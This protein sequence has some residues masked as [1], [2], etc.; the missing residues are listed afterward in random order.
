MSIE[1]YPV[2]PFPPNWTSTVGETLEWLTDILQSPTGSEQ[3]RSL[4]YFP[5]RMINFTISAEGEEHSLLDMLLSAYG[6][7][8][9]YLPVW[10]NT[11]IA[12][13]A[14]V[15]AVIACEPGLG[16]AVGTPVFISGPTVYDYQ[17]G[18]V[19]SMTSTSITLVDAPSTV[20]PA[21]TLIYPMTVGRLIEQPN[22]TAITDSLV[23][24][25]PQFKITAPTADPGV[26]IRT[27]GPLIV[28]GLIANAYHKE[29]GRGGYFHPN[30]GTSEGQFIF[31]Y[32]L[33]CAYEQLI[34]G[35]Q[36]EK[37]VAR[38][39]KTLAEEMLD[40]IGSGETYLGPMLRQPIPAGVNTITL[41]HW[42]FAAKGDIPGQEIVLAYECERDGAYLTIPPS[43][44]GDNVVKV[45]Q[46]Y[47]VSSEL[48]YDSP[49][50]PAFDIILPAGETQI[51]VEDDDWEILS[52]G[53]R[54][55]LPIGGLEHDTWKIVYAFETDRVVPR[56][57]GYDVHPNWT[58]IAPGY[59][60]S[61]P[62]TFRWFEQAMRK[63]I[64]HDTRIGSTAKWTALRNAMRRTAVRGQSIT[65]LREVFEPMPGFSAIPVSGSPTGMYCFSDHPD[66]MGPNV[67]G[68]DITWTGY[69]FW[70]R[71][72]N[73]DILGNVPGDRTPSP[74]MLSPAE[75]A[76]ATYT[77]LTYEIY[78]IGLSGTIGVDGVVYEFE[79]ATLGAIVDTI[80]AEQPNVTATFTQTFVPIFNVYATTI[81]VTATNAGAAGNLIEV[82]ETG[83]GSWAYEEVVTTHLMGGVDAVYAGAV[84][85]MPQV[86]LGRVFKDQWRTSETYQEADQ[87]LYVA[88]SVDKEP[89]ADIKEK[90]L[91]YVSSTEHYDPS[92]RWYADIGSLEE[93]VATTG[94]VIEFFIPRTAFRLRI[95]DSGGDTTWGSV[96]PAGTSLLSF[97]IALELWDAY[98]VRLRAMRLVSDNT[99][100]AV[101][102][103]DMPF[104]PGALPFTINADLRRQYFTEVEGLPFHGYQ[105]PDHW[106]WLGADADAV[107]P[108]LAAGDLAIAASDGSLTYPISATT[109][110]GASKPRNA[111]LMEQQLMFL[112]AAQDRYA[113][114]GG[115]SGF[116][117]HTFVL[118]T[119]VR[120]SIGN[121]TPHTWVYVNDDPNTSWVGYQTRVVESLAELVL[122]TTG[123]AGF[124]DA[125]DLAVSVVE[126][127]LERLNIV[128][129]NLSGQDVDGVLIY[130]M[131]TNYPD[132]SHSDPYAAYEEPH[133]AAH[134]LRAC[135]TLKSVGA[136]NTARQN[137]LISRCWAYLELLWRTAG[138]MA[139]TW[140]PNPDA[141][142]WYGTWH[143]DIITTLAMMIEHSAMLPADVPLETVKQR[144]VQTQSW[145][146]QWGLSSLQDN[147]EAGLIER[148][149]RFHVLTLESNWTDGTE[150]GQQRLLSEF[151]PGTG[152]YA[153]E[154]TAMRPFPTIRLNWLLDGK[155]DHAR[156]YS[157]MQAMRGRAV[158]V[159]VPTWMT[160]MRM[161]ENLDA[162]SS[163]I[164]VARCGF[165]LAGGPIPERQD[166]MIELVDGRRF[167]RRILSSTMS[168]ANEVI[169]IDN[170]LGVS[171]SPKDVLRISFMSLMRLDHDSIE[172]DHITDAD[173]ASEVQVTFR[174]APDTR[175]PE[176]A[177][178]EV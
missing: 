143:G 94:D 116:F 117:A 97:G 120:E 71:A 84:I 52:T 43:A 38:W 137:A 145:L 134:V 23:T 139:Y 153:V 3:R 101:A 178:Y 148:Y 169:E 83:D 2:W 75:K 48:L 35:T 74:V 159:W 88:M 32:G 51:L 4:R 136:G 92:T 110:G 8:E 132:P 29:I 90:V 57:F 13:A 20:V 49:F 47:P 125:R 121:P 154:D 37:A 11:T 127:W 87:Y 61:A 67:Q 12:S 142:Q 7:Q 161:T 130:G 69:N 170:P 123:D 147:E 128:W 144:L 59:A 1:N 115:P 60:S 163:T 64:A 107:H 138:E 93:F 131:P 62:D 82:T 171:A 44:N 119:P 78:G 122:L 177:F 63:A 31:I 124:S 27:A 129:P 56:T 176:P 30:S 150:R 133:A 104:F 70:S 85:P 79:R 36:E 15:G 126:N 39:Y 46:I 81:V 165:T 54:I 149:R 41:L 76:T 73:G 135:L 80:N 96:L 28:D 111:L 106:W 95:I 33:Y 102:G 166:I 24:A 34:D 9:W 105:L 6:S 152:K 68:G 164:T 58:S 167:Y 99:P 86:Q 17:V 151:D 103:A 42:L 158:P 53:C 118:N 155:S 162:D 16:I 5:R 174:A 55:S 173:G 18:E 40:A 146:E 156:F 168:G 109:V 140:S 108:A 21:G 25:E 50:S 141:R 45:W 114:D 91:V 26:T 19:A 113:A 77:L 172:I 175:K 14:S 22:T 98:Q 65:D 72:P 100:E 10:Y 89:I 157:L 160:D 112:E 66:A